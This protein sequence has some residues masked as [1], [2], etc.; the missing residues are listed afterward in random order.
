M[1]LELQK[2][3][4]AN[5]LRRYTDFTSGRIRNASNLVY[6]KGSIIHYWPDQLSIAGPSNQ[7]PFLEE[8]ST[9]FID[10]IS[11]LHTN[12]GRPMPSGLQLNTVLSNY[13]RDHRRYKALVRD[14][15]LTANKLNMLVVNYAPLNLLYRYTPTVK[16]EYYRW[17]NQAR[18]FI[19]TVNNL[20]Q[21]IPEWAQFIEVNFEAV[22]ERKDYIRLLSTISKETLSKVQGGSGFFL[23]ELWK[24]LQFEPSIFDDLTTEATEALRI[25]VRHNARFSVFSLTQFKEWMSDRDPKTNIKRAAQLAPT[26]APILFLSYLDNLVV[27]EEVEDVEDTAPAQVS[28]ATPDDLNLDDLFN[29]DLEL[30]AAKAPKPVDTTAEEKEISELLEQVRTDPLTSS[31]E[32]T[33][34][35]LLK[36]KMISKSTYERAVEDALTFKTLENPWGGDETLD[37]FRTI[38][39]DDLT[40]PERQIIEDR[41]AIFDKSFLESTV[42]A[43]QRKYVETVLPKDIVSSVLSVQK[44]NVAVKD[45]KIERKEDAV[46]AYEIHRVTVKP[47]RG[48]KSVLEF[49]VPIFDEQ[50]KFMSNGNKQVMRLQR[51]DLPI[52][53]VKPNRVV[54][55]SYYGKIFV[56]RVT[57]KA[58]N[59]GD[60]LAQT[61]IKRGF[62]NEDTSITQLELN[63]VF[64]RKEKLPYT[65][66]SVAASVGRFTAMVN[67]RTFVFEFDYPRRKSLFTEAALSMENDE[68][69]VL[70]HSANCTLYIDLRDQVYL[71]D[72]AQDTPAYTPLG[73][74]PSVLGISTANA[75]VPAV[76]MK[77]LDK[78]IPVGLALGYTMGLSKLVELLECQIRKVPRGERAVLASHEYRLTFDNETWVL[79]R[80]DRRA[81]LILG[82]LE[83]QNKL[84]RQYSTEDFDGKDVYYRILEENKLSSRYLRKLDNTMIS[85]M[86]H[87]TEE[88]LVSMGEPTTV[89]GLL[90]RAAEMLM[91]EDSPS[92]VAPEFMRYRGP[93][94][95]AGI[96]YQEINR[97]V[98]AFNNRNGQDRTIAL[99]PISIWQKIVQDPAVLLV[100]EANPIQ[101]L[102]EQEGTTYRGF[103]GRP[104]RAMTAESRIFEERDRGVTSESTVD[105]GA[106]GVVNFLS[107][108]ANFDSVRGLTRAFDPAK[109]GNASL[110]STSMLL[111]PLADHDDRC[112]NTR[113]AGLAINQLCAL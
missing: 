13:R 54:C 1:R 110:F 77:I 7:E 55:S 5:G 24:F 22:P 30:G 51:I 28:H 69:K 37:E 32:S 63:S 50:N 84:L 44:Q 25:V 65:Y 103:G 58:S 72:H 48:G 67:G 105:S 102:R 61:I 53:K 74:F 79:S 41:S 91:T 8:V 70:A 27:E 26:R 59:Y 81:T 23:F 57:R 100:E 15:A 12:E 14:R 92:V 99:N 2:W 46:N 109:D 19:A 60:W 16:T 71:V 39:A 82:G 6:P 107:P 96:I 95:V 42:L 75:P 11:T 89:E 18:T 76:E 40:I 104:D 94:R 101:C 68:R 4:R 62:D 73:D 90:V 112:T 31:I 33:A 45:Y 29:D 43:T 35:A 20:A 9:T 17:Y 36:N 10:H 98:E 64:T 108:N 113:S 78:T 97:A 86:D 56:E 83:R 111:A 93:E 38:K 106:V 88:I 80:A 3:L 66:T 21:R 85:W 87:I 34:S 47:L 52:R 49:R